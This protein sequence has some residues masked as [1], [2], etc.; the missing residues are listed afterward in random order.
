MCLNRPG[1]TTQQHPE[2]W[3][4]QVLYKCLEFSIKLACFRMLNVSPRQFWGV[5][6]AEKKRKYTIY[7]INSLQL[8]ELTSCSIRNT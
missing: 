1:Q 8:W 5:H 6:K 3:P 4:E 2:P 7:Q